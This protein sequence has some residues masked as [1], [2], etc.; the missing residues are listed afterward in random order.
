MSPVVTAVE[1]SSACQAPP[2]I[3]LFPSP[4]HSCSQ[5]NK[6]LITSHSLTLPV[7]VAGQVQQHFFDDSSV[8]HKIVKAEP[9]TTATLCLS[10]RRTSTH[11]NTPSP[12]SSH[13]LP[14][15]STRSI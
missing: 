1:A 5:P 4:M 9:R 15:L 6:M 8:K 2:S 14:R 11:H 3:A 10:E 13:I 7:T 12:V